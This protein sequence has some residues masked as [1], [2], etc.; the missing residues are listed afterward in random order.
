MA[1][2]YSSPATWQL[3]APFVAMFQSTMLED[4]AMVS[5]RGN[6]RRNPAPIVAGSPTRRKKFVG[7]VGPVPHASAVCAVPA[8]PA[9]SVS[10]VIGEVGV[11]PMAAGV[12]IPYVE[13]VAAFS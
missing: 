3:T 4:T 10:Q 13:A 8:G 6:V 12:P 9:C 1:T 2:R 7:A 11:T 5:P